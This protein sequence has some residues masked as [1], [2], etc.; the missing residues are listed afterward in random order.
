MNAHALKWISL[1]YLVLASGAM[2]QAS[3]LAIKTFDKSGRL[4]FPAVRGAKMHDLQTYATQT[5]SRIVDTRVN[6]TA[7]DSMAVVAPMTAGAGFF[8]IVVSRE[9]IAPAGMMLI[10][11]RPV[12]VKRNWDGYR[13]SC[14]SLFGLTQVSECQ[15]WILA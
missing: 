12:T 3:D 11:E 13:L 6:L 5:E 15:S 8:R 9:E 7:A 1:S 10:P 4:V 14:S 2:S